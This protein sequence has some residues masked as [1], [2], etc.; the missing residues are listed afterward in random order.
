MD[1]TVALVPAVS[2]EPDRAAGGTPGLVV[3]EHTLTNLSNGSETFLLSASSSLGWGV[4]VQPAS[5]LLAQG[6]TAT[7]KV[8]V[9]IPASA[10]PGTVDVTTVTATS[11][12]DGSVS[13]TATDSTTRQ[14]YPYGVYLPLVRRS[15]P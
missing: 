9:S 4:S 7:V 6:G 2:L 8:F 11:Q 3:Y 13:D 15:G 14:A 12:S 10:A 5:V 1:T